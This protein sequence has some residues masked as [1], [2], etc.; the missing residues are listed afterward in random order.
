MVAVTFPVPIDSFAF[1]YTEI[2]IV[3]VDVLHSLFGG[4]IDPLSGICYPWV[5]SDIQFLFLSA[6]NEDV[7]HPHVI[8]HIEPAG[9]CGK[10]VDVGLEQAPAEVECCTVLEFAECQIQRSA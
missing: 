7:L 4:R 8:V 1:F 10:V 9:V 2:N 3:G 6:E 5:L